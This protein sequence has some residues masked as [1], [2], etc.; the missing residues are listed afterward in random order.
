[1]NNGELKAETCEWSEDD[2][3][4]W[5]CSK[6]DIAWEFTSDG[7]RENGVNYCPGCGWKLGYRED[8]A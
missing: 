7:P 2:D 4:V 6:C 8:K 3:G 1:M 5:T